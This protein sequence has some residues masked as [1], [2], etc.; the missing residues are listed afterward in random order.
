MLFSMS[1][2]SKVPATSELVRSCFHRTIIHV[3]GVWIED[4]RCIA[5]PGAD[6]LYIDCGLVSDEAL[7]SRCP[8]KTVVSA[9][10]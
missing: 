6:G 1:L 5:P 9:Q 10:I 7:A 2:V 3:V 8:A 4:A